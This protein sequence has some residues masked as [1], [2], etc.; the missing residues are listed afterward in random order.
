MDENAEVQSNEILKLARKMCIFMLSRTR[1][2][3]LIK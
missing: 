1:Y 3:Y 2:M